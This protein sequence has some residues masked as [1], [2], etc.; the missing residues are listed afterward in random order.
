[1]Y[2]QKD[3]ISNDSWASQISDHFLTGEPIPS[4][5]LQNEYYKADAAAHYP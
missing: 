5:D 1:M 2:K 3:K 4:L